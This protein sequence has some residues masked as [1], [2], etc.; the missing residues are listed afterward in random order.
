MDHLADTL[1]SGS[2]IKQEEWKRTKRWTMRKEEGRGEE[3]KDVG[4]NKKLNNPRFS[5]RKDT[6]TIPME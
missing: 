2:Y 6:A 5:Q 1:K 3:A 4:K